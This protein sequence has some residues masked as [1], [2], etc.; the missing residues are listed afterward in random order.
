MIFWHFLTFMNNLWLFCRLL[1]VNFWTCLLFGSHI[2][3]YDMALGL[4]NVHLL[5]PFSFLFILFEYV[6]NDLTLIMFSPIW[7]SFTSSIS[8]N[9]I[10]IS[11]WISMTSGQYAIMMLIVAIIWINCIV[12]IFLIAWHLLWMVKIFNEFFYWIWYIL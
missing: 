12:I 8:G 2:L 11:Y 1:I 6:F 7:Y 3:I 5:F 10:T 4:M 9:R